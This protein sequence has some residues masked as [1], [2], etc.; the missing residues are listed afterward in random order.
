MAPERVVAEARSILAASDAG[1][2]LGDPDARATPGH[3][4]HE[5]VPDAGRDASQRHYLRAQTIGLLTTARKLAGEPITHAD[6]VEACYGV[7]PRRF[8]QEEFQAA[9]RRLDELVPGDGP[10]LDRYVSWREARPVPVDRL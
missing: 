5:I 2:P 7:R 3:W 1:E 9:H 4:Q 10:L 8:E 6:E